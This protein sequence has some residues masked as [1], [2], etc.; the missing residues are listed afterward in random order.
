MPDLDF[1]GHNTLYAS[2]GLHSYAAKCPP[3]LARYGVRYYSHAGDTVLDPM[4]GS[5]TTL[6]EAK[7]LG[8][9]AI[10]YDI[11][12]LAH[13]LARVKTQPL[14]DCKIE[15][16]HDVIL[17]RCQRDLKDLQSRTKSA[18]LRKRAE[19]PSFNNRDYWFAPEVASSL[20]LL[21]YH[22][23]ES[24]S[25][26]AVSDFLWVA[27]SS[28]I[29]SKTSVANARDI[30]HSRHHYH[31]H[32]QVPD[33][34][35]KFTARV[36]V[37]RRQMRDFVQ[38]CSKSPKTD[39]H[40]RVGDARHLRVEDESV[41]LVFT[42]PPYATALDY[43]RAHFLAIPWMTAVLGVDLPA[44]F[45]K[46]PDYIG[47]ERGRFRTSFEV[48]PTLAGYPLTRAIIGRLQKN[49]LRHAKLT[50]RYFLDMKRVMAEVSRVLKHEGYAIIVVCPSHIRKVRVQTH[51][52]LTEISV[53]EGLRLKRQFTRTINER[54]RLLPYVRKSF[55]MRMD[56][57][58]ILIFQK[59]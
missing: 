30:I 46:T 35:E 43:P 55:G 14:K 47:S 7:I 1:D 54:R 9:H 17:K 49:S 41:D 56:T 40:T 25:P 45:S 8:R 15:A 2:H 58:Y 3:Q 39:V 21:S 4:A 53:Q 19:P 5:G 13:L 27:L 37:M 29:L 18:A 32:K 23:A 20:S 44:Y 28:L 59:V 38:R 26:K 33:V 31:E 36:K 50:Q 48:S 22:I 51:R 42:S 10:G 6:I 12:P 52:V 11:D 57:E 34:L 24:R 16:A